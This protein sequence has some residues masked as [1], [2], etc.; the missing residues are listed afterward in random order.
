MS[1]RE[2]GRGYICKDKSEREE[3]AKKKRI[4]NKREGEVNKS[5]GLNAVKKYK[6]AKR[7][8]EAED[9]R[10]TTTLFSF[11]F[12]LIIFTIIHLNSHPSEVAST[13]V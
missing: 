3:K 12:Q 11:L 10:N 7:P 13:M 6:R 9:D 2:R 8:A 4:E 5:W 1:H